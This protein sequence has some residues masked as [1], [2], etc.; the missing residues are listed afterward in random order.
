M[1]DNVAVVKALCCFIFL[2]YLFCDIL[3]I[4]RDVCV[5]VYFVDCKPRPNV[6]VTA[7]NVNGFVD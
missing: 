7:V 2:H 4:R 3:I 6:V 1:Q 5:C